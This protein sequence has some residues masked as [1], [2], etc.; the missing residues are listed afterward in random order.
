MLLFFIII[1]I[2][3]LQRILG[4]CIALRAGEGEADTGEE[5]LVVEPRTLL[6]LPCCQGFS[7]PGMSATFG[8]LSQAPGEGGQG[9]QGAGT[10]KRTAPL[11]V[12]GACGGRVVFFL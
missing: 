12:S 4:G 10:A 1:I 6:P 5:G 8:A 11:V 9:K 3:F 2:I 7:V